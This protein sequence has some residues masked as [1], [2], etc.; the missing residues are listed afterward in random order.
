M[1]DWRFKFLRT[2]TDVRSIGK[3]DASSYFLFPLKKVPEPYFYFMEE[4]DGRFLIGMYHR[5]YAFLGVV[6]LEYG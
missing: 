1:K 5:I 4:W 6:S 2:G 3:I